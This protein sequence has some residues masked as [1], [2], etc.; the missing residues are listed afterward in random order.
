MSEE[1]RFSYLRPQQ[2]RK[3]RDECPIAYI[4]L[5]N[6]EWHGFHNPFG[7]DSLIAEHLAI[8]CARI[9]GGISM[10]P[11]HW[12]DNR[13]NGI[14]DAFIDE[15]EEIAAAMGCDPDSNTIARWNRDEQEQD[16]LFHD[17]LLHILNQTENYGFRAAV[18]VC[19]HYPHLR[20]A[21]NAAEEY[22]RGTEKTGKMLAWAVTEGKILAGRYPLS[23]GHS[24]GWETSYLLASNPESVDLSVLP[25]EGSALLGVF[26]KTPPHVADGE[27]GKQLYREA[28]EAITEAA[29]KLLYDLSMDEISVSESYYEE[30][31]NMDDVEIL[32]EP[33]ELEFDEKGNMV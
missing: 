27:N 32:S 19:G 7:T 18:F 33:F 20:R 23:G 1:V 12:G 30:L 2:L 24:S 14:V 15:C 25:P 8:Q 10:P 5:G 21:A 6:L 31:R 17:L 29:R 11:L 9:G 16:K 26:G 13:L 3:R 22:N 28:A 4:P